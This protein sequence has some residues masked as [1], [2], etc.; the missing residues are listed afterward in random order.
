MLPQKVLMNVSVDPLAGA[1]ENDG[2]FLA[3]ASQHIQDHLLQRS[4]RF[5]KDEDAGIHI[6]HRDVCQVV[7]VAAVDGHVPSENFFI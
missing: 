3:V 4:L 2:A 5:G 6:G 7:A 1:N